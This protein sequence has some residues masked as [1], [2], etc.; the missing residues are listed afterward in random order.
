MKSRFDIEVVI[1][2]PGD[3]RI[4][5]MSVPAGTTVRQAI[6]RV[7]HQQGMDG[8]EVNYHDVGIYSRKCN[9]D[10]LVSPGDRIEI[11]RPLVIEPKN[12]RKLKAK[13]SQ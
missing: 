8:I 2:A 5:E 4:V 1:T 12:R 10:K 3:A 9:V 13:L 11:Y 7:R 6:E